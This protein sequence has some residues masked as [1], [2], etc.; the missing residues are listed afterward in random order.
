VNYSHKE[1]KSK[2]Y[3]RPISIP[4]CNSDFD[5]YKTLSKINNHKEVLGPNFNL[6]TSR[7][8]GKNSLPCFVQVKNY[9][10]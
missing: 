2:K 1:T 10:C 6:M 8:Q 9:I 4:L 5:P 3:D 7:P